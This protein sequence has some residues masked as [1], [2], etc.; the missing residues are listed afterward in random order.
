VSLDENT[1]FYPWVRVTDEWGVLEANGGLL[2]RDNGRIVKVVVPAAKDARGSS[3]KGE[4]WR[5]DLAPTWGIVPGAR[6]G[7]QTLEKEPG[8][9]VAPTRR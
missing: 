2:V 8:P 4:D 6:S 3:V 1:A 5:L 9:S 7:D